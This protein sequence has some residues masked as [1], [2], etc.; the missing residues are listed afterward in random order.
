[1]FVSS[2]KLTHL[3]HQFLFHNR[4]PPAAGLSVARQIAMVSYRTPH[5]YQSKFGRAVNESGDFEA[6][7]YLQ[8]QGMKFLDRFD[9]LTYVKIT[10]QMDTHDVGRGRGGIDAAL[11][12]ITSRVM[13]MGIDSDLLYPLC[14]QEELAKKIPQCTFKVIKSKEGH[15]GFLLE[16]KQVA[17]NISLFLNGGE[18]FAK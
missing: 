5:A 17:D 12:S 10:E 16:Q 8:Y 9:A 15:D 7:S 2:Y 3:P 14:E 11:A 13:V 6:K 4:D 18:D 1:M